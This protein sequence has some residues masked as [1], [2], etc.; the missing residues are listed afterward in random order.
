MIKYCLHPGKVTSKTDGDIHYIGAA[1]L[2]DLYR[3]DIRE[4]HVYEELGGHI[5]R[6]DDEF[7]KC[8]YPSPSGN[9]LLTPEKGS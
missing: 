8:L 1:R 7:L 9:Y 3:V 5:P 6:I 2:A 4:C